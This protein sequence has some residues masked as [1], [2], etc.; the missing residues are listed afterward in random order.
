MQVDNLE[1]QRDTNEFLAQ[2]MG[3]LTDNQQMITTQVNNNTNTNTNAPNTTQN[4]NNSNNADNTNREFTKQI[5]KQRVLSDMEFSPKKKLGA[6]ANDPVKNQV[7]NWNG[8]VKLF[9]S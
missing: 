6:S 5:E 1:A 3:R 7:I 2:I 8:I 9:D 4:T